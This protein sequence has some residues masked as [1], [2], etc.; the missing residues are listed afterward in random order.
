MP[1]TT[2][3]KPSR[4]SPV[5]PTSPPPQPPT[6]TANGSQ[7]AGGAR[8]KSPSPPRSTYIERESSR[9]AGETISPTTGLSQSQSEL[10]SSQSLSSKTRTVETVTVCIK[11]SSSN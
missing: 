1:S 4:T 2:P 3:S 10:I 7:G 11:V 6:T 5:T 9:D 8:T